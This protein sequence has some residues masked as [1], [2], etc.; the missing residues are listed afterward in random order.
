MVPG[1][2]SG[3]QSSCF[4]SLDYTSFKQ[5][6]NKKVYVFLILCVKCI[7]HVCIYFYFQR[8][9]SIAKDT[10][11]GKDW[12]QKEQGMRWLDRITNSMDMS[13]SELQET[14]EDRG[15]WCA[16]VHGVA[17]S[18]TRLSK[19]KQQ[20]QYIWKQIQISCFLFGLFF[21]I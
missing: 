14:A 7:F 15:V 17:K 12:Y 21:C 5:N 18:Q 10:D 8:A 4:Q 1:F 2:E 13:L 9:N 19:T 20:Q 16:G 3:I 6:T 11:V